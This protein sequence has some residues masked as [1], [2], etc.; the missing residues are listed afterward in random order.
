M[1]AL[2]LLQYGSPAVIAW[3]TIGGFNRLNHRGC[4]SLS[5]ALRP[6]RQVRNN[7]AGDAAEKRMELKGDLTEK[8]RLFFRR[9]SPSNKKM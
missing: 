3:R 6:G 1:A 2:Q 8:V 7:T 5:K 4:L 9:I